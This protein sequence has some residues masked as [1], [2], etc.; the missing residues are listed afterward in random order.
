M[1]S[2]GAKTQIP[3]DDLVVEHH[4]IQSLLEDATHVANRK[5]AISCNRAAHHI[6]H[7]AKRLLPVAPLSCPE[8]LM[9]P[10]LPDKIAGLSANRPIFRYLTKVRRQRVLVP[11]ALRKNDPSA[12]T[13]I[14]GSFVR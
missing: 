11:E 13:E 14:E 1:M 10:G 7:V 8:M 12:D 9:V 3:L 4:R 6:V 5:L 2:F